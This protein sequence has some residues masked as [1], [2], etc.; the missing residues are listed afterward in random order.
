MCLEPKKGVVRRCSIKKDVLKNF[1]KLTEKKHLCWSLFV[2]K[3]SG[4]QF[5]LKGDSD[6]V[7]FFW[8][9]A[10]FLRTPFSTEHLRWLLL[11]PA[12]HSWYSFFVSGLTA[13]W[14]RA[15]HNRYL[16]GSYSLVTKTLWQISKKFH[17]GSSK[18]NDWLIG[19]WFENH[20]KEYDCT[21]SISKELQQTYFT[22]TFLLLNIKEKY[23]KDNT[24]STKDKKDITSKLMEFQLK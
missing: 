7:V 12:K 17:F 16:T 8:F 1:A 6:T 20:N 2:N 21:S 10:K 13:I 19:E 24:K 18:S 23:T 15:H 22:M 14:K 11:D 4:L 5:N 9:F 3:V